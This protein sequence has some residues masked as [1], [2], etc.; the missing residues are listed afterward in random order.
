[1]KPYHLQIR[2]DP[3]TTALTCL[4]FG[5]SAIHAAGSA[6]HALRPAAG[7]TLVPDPY[8]IDLQPLLAEIAAGAISD[9]EAMKIFA[10]ER[11]YAAFEETIEETLRL[12]PMRILAIA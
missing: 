8:L 10:A 2:L 9:A 7:T 4:W 5:P 12:H 1:M 6:H 3:R 11:D